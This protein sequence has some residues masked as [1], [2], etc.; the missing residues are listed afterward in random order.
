MLQKSQLKFVWFLKRQLGVLVPPSPHPHLCPGLSLSSLTQISDKGPHLPLLMM[1]W[2]A[3]ASGRG[4]E[5]G[6]TV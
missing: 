3:A 2:R 1:E 6:E 4:S 5:G